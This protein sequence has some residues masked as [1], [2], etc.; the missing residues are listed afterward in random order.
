MGRDFI[1]NSHPPPRAVSIHAPTWGATGSR[2]V[3]GYSRKFQFTRPRGA[4]HV[5]TLRIAATPRFNSRAH[6]G[7]DQAVPQPLA[8]VVVSIHAPTWGATADYDYAFRLY[9]FNSRAH[10]GRDGDIKAIVHLVGV[11]IHAPTWGAT[12]KNSG[13]FSAT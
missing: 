9:G 1:I 12:A 2:A 11:S 4:R 10:V 5:A 6:V 7:R 13:I 3:L 8:L